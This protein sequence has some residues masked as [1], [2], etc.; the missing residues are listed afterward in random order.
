[1]QMQTDRHDDVGA[2]AHAA[3]LSEW[4]RLRLRLVDL[5]PRR[6]PWWQTAADLTLTVVV[7]SALGAVLAGALLLVA[8]A[9]SLFLGL[10]T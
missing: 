6:V 9:G 7:A 1:M 10:F 8:F 5:P 3:D 4:Q 2:K